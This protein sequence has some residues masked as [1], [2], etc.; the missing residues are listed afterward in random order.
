MSNI[1]YPFTS[2]SVSEGHPDKVADQISDAIL[3]AYLERDP[4]SKVACECLITSGQLIIAGEVTSNACINVDKI[5]R[6]VITD[7]GYISE[8]LGFDA[9]KATIHNLLHEQSRE[10]NDSVIDGGAGDQGLVFGYATDES[11]ELLPL[12]I[13]ISHRLVE[14]QAKLRKDGSIPWLRPDAKSQVTVRY[15]DGVPTAVEKVVLSTQHDPGIDQQE[16]RQTV[17][18][19]IIQ[20]VLDQYFPDS[21][22]EFLVNPSGSFIVGGPHGDTGLTGRKIIVDTYGGSCPHGGGAFS[23][24]DPTKVD[25]SGA[26]AARYVAKHV[27]AAGLAKRCTVQISYAIGVVEPTSL[28][29]DTHKTGIVWD[30]LIESKVFALFDLTPQGIIRKLGLKQPIYSQT[31]TYGHFGKN[32]LPW[33]QLDPDIIEA[34]KVLVTAKRTSTFNN[35]LLAVS[36]EINLRLKTVI[37]SGTIQCWHEEKGPLFFEPSKREWKSLDG[38]TPEKPFDF[39][40]DELATVESALLDYSEKRRAYFKKAQASV[41]EQLRHTLP[42]KN[43]PA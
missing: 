13:L 11:P 17:I 8:D 20:P 38:P 36:P 19:K 7:I 18:E 34:L 5:A 3:D 23:G 30:R 27:V 14:A 39:N 40:A 28:L 32:E 4:E 33:E 21:T 37:G 31:A 15:V 35:R 25:R 26:Y 10:I 6:K 43:T 2:E 24:K 22:P 29:I 12:P 9:E 41:N 16:I 42:S 1:S